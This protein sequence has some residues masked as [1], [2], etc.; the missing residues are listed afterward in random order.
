MLV[1]LLRI[2]DERTRIVR[3]SVVQGAWCLGMFAVLFFW[4]LWRRL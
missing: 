3:R 1:E 4:D 2:R